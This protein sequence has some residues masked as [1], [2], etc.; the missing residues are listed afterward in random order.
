MLAE[1]VKQCPKTNIK[2]N[3]DKWCSEADLLPIDA[4]P[5]AVDDLVFKITIRY[6]QGGTWDYHIATAVRTCEDGLCVIDPNGTAST[7]PSTDCV[8][9]Q[10]WAEKYAKIGPTGNEAVVWVSYNFYMS[11]K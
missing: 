5:G 3:D 4:N 2:G 6:P 10:A 11:S 7:T 1:L 9:P 8:T